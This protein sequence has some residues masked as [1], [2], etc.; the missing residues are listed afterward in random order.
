LTMAVNLSAVQLVDDNLVELV[1]STLRDSGIVP[2][3]LK[4]ELTESAVMAEPE[5]AMG[6]FKRLKELGAK[7][8]LD[9][10][11]TGYSSLSHLRRL[12]IDTLKIDRSFVSQMDCQEDKR[13]IAE[14]VMMLA[15][16]LGLEVVAEG[17][18]TAAEVAVLQEMGSDFVQGYFYFRPM[19]AADA[20][21]A[22]HQQLA[23]LAST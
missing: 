7:L 20:G 23:L 5:R 21:A 2:G 12:P 15:R 4:L 17:A 6:I 9:D 19:N 11:G 16:T 13:Q 10:F 18:E 1:A 8:S 14:V 22:L 3:T